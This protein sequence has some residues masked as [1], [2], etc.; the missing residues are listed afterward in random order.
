ME[1]LG[2]VPQPPQPHSAQA[3]LLFEFGEQSLDLV[4]SALRTLIG[5]RAGQR[6]YDLP[7]R[8]LRIH[9]QPAIGRRGT[10]LLLRAALALRRRRAVGVALTVAA[11]TAIAQRFSFGTVVSVLLGLIAELLSGEAST[12]LVTAVDDRNVG[13]DV[14]LQQPGQKLSAAVGFVGSQAF[15]AKPQLVY[16]LQYPPGGQHLLPEARRRGLH[17]HNDATGRID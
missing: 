3:Y 13:L 2:H 9:E 1:L 8:F 6:A 11:L 10:A 14:P 7:G 16:L 12:R 17:R 5:W 15:R 4:T